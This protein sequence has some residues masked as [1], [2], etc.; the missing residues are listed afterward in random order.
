M[1]NLLPLFKAPTDKKLLVVLDLDLT[2]VHAVQLDRNATPAS[3]C[4]CII[5]NQELQAMGYPNAPDQRNIWTRPGFREF[6]RQLSEFADI[7]VWTLS[8]VR[9]PCSPAPLAPSRNLAKPCTNAVISF[10]VLRLTD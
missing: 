7:I 5:T 8:Q 6:L 4:S 3:D 2:L 10:A 1:T 9:H